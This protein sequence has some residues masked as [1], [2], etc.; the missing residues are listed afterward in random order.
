LILFIN[1]ESS[2]EDYIGNS[3]RN[4]LS[5]HLKAINKTKFEEAKED[6][7]SLRDFVLESFKVVLDFEK[8][9]SIETPK[10]IIKDKFNDITINIKVPS[11]LGHD[12]VDKLN[13]SDLL[14]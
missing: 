6:H 4:V 3:W 12:I 7:K 5:L 9:K 8:K 2:L 14:R 11:S 13:L 1:S 10:N